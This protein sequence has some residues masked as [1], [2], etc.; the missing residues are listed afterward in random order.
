VLI[1]ELKEVIIKPIY[2]MEEK[3]DIQRGE[4][5]SWN[6]TVRQLAKDLSIYQLEIMSRIGRKRKWLLEANI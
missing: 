5:A 1:L 2:L 4:V 6:H 3:T